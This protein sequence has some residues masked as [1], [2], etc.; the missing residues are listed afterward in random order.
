M[1][2]GI[3]LFLNVIFLCAALYVMIE[4]LREKES[5]ASLFGLA[6]L[7]FHII[8]I[9]LIIWVPALHVPIAILFCL[10][11]LAFVIFSIPSKPDPKSLKG[12][13]GHV[14]GDVK[15]F[16]ERD[17]LFART[18]TFSPEMGQFEEYYQR[19]PEFKEYDDHQ[20]EQGMWSRPPGTIDK[21]YGPY[22]AM[23][24]ASDHAINLMGDSAVVE[25]SSH[26]SED[27]LSPEQATE[28][29]KKYARHLGADLVG[30]CKVNALWAYTH[31]GAVYFDKSEHGNELPES[32]PYALVYAVEMSY[33]HVS[34]APHSPTML[35]SM[36]QYARGTFISTTL[37]Q[38]FSGMGYHAR[39]QHVDHYDHL[40]VP[41]AVDAGLGEMGRLG[42]LIA[43]K[44]GARIR[45][46]GVT[47][48]MPLIPDKPISVGAEQ[49]CNKCKKCATSC[50]SGS[51]PL[52]E[53]TIHNGIERW[54][55]N[56]QTCYD[57]WGKAGTDCA[58][59]MAICPFNRPDTPL[60]QLVR[61]MVARSSLARSIFPYIENLIYGKKWRPKKFTSWL[62]YNLDEKETF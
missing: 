13:M 10:Y 58:I 6:G 41:M 40:M 23:L 9:P 16:D 51:I 54:K 20:R 27:H 46:F 59:C 3:L 8:L 5:R 42:Y 21:H 7:L 52:E 11:V 18:E 55:L 57:F 34:T 56:D 25:P 60:H 33:E 1:L 26:A 50:P 39:A 17:T 24:G 38:W 43:P 15:R 44:F 2:I 4:S 32:L 36:H 19:H 47:T 30:I 61:W 12:S 45:V 14:M 31:R 62:D 22:L 48:D 37:A 35:E 29:V 53:K 28:M 49:F